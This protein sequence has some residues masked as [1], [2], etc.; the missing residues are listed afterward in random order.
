MGINIY[1]I[2]SKEAKTDYWEETMAICCDGNK[3]HIY[4]VPLFIYI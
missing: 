3:T 1:K 2:I 4:N